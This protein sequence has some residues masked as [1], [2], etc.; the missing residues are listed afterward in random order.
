MN[1]LRRIVNLFT[2]FHR[3]K[4][5]LCVNC[6]H[7]VPR[8]SGMEYSQCGR[9]GRVSKVDGE[10]LKARNYCNLSRRVLWH[11]GPGGC[12]YEV[13][14]MLVKVGKGKNF[15]QPGAERKL[16]IKERHEV[17]D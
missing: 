17:T 6:K 13:K 1:P 3:K 11:C 14:P 10:A 4:T 7:W 8:P 9:S 12:H 16:Y 15:T 5:V 2:Y